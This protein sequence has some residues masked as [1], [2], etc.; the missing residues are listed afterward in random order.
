[1]EKKQLP[2]AITVG[3]FLE[4]QGLLPHDE[5]VPGL[6]GMA[7][8]SIQ[9]LDFKD[10]QTLTLPFVGHHVSLQLVDDFIML[11]ISDYN[12]GPWRFVQTK[13]TSWNSFRDHALSW[14]EREQ[15]RIL[16]VTEA[17]S[18]AL[19]EKL[20]N[21]SGFSVLQDV[22]ELLK[23]DL[24][25]INKQFE[26][27]EWVGGHEFPLTPV[28]FVSPKRTQPNP[29]ILSENPFPGA[30]IERQDIPLLWY[31]L[32]AQQ[33][34]LGYLGLGAS[35]ESIGSIERLLLHKAATLLVLELAKGQCVQDN[36]RHYQRDFLFDLLY[37]NFDSLEVI[38]SRG[39][40]WRWDFNKPHFVVVGE[41]PGFDPDSSQQE[42]FE[43]ILTEIAAILRSY[44][45][46]TICLERNGQ[47]VMLFPVQDMLASSAWNDR[48]QTLLQPIINFMAQHS[49]EQQLSFGFGNLYPTARYIHRSFQE[50]RSALELG[51][52]FS[53][54][55]RIIAFQDLG[56][57]RLLYKVDRQEL[58]DYRTEVLG[59]LLKFDQEN[60]LALEDTLLAYFA[61]STDLKAAGDRL[62]LHPNTLRYRLKK[63]AEIL[64]RDL[65]VLE[66]QVNLFIALKIGKLK[67][68]WPE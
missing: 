18:Q 2:Q 19:A 53:L 11:G 26:V 15:G 8:E 37:N 36:E 5:S 64:G 33:G 46:Q 56:I 23:F 17:F 30:W 21:G 40:L 47:I 55:A 34:I 45:P 54:D 41:I 60:N 58:E 7:Q 31:P 59:P 57:M 12:G 32:I 6:E 9:C 38:I 27:L 39:K 50:A 14:L 68:L 52:L 61:A 35:L 25:I 48:V 42:A 62:F 49:Q 16:A 43:T 3:R 66:N 63:A 67:S 28:S 1:M 44:Y 29:N 10:F 20:A 13:Q 4:A 65:S 24:C 22:R 51:Q